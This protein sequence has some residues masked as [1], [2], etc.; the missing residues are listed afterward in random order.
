MY[1]DG[2]KTFLVSWR[3]RIFKNLCI[4]RT[5]IT[6]LLG[7]FFLLNG[8]ARLK[9]KIKFKRTACEV[10]AESSQNGTVSFPFG[11]GRMIKHG[12]DHFVKYYSQCFVF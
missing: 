2:A 7:Y 12:T 9:M 8:N 5:G 4:D 10:G 6:I 3:G 1:F 11:F